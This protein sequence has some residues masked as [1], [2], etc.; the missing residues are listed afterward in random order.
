M[1]HFKKQLK[2][3][4]KRPVSDVRKVIKNKP[5][6]LRND[7]FTV[8][9][10]RKAFSEF[11]RKYRKLTTT[12][13]IVVVIWIGILIQHRIT[14]AETTMFFPNACLGGWENP[15][16]ASG[17]PTLQGGSTNNDFNK[18]NSAVLQANSLSELYCGEFSGTVPDEAQP[19]KVVLSLSGVIK[20]EQAKEIET[21]PII[22][23]DNATSTVEEILSSPAEDNN[24]VIITEVVLPENSPSESETTEL[25]QLNESDVNAKP[26]QSLPPE[27]PSA[28]SEE[29]SAPDEINNLQSLL[30]P[31]I[32]VAYAS[33]ATTSIDVAQS[34][35]D[36]YQDAVLEVFYTLDTITWNSL[37]KVAGE[38]IQITQFE[39]PSDAIADWEDL[40]SL[41]I[42]VARVTSIDESPTLLID[43]MTLEVT[44]DEINPDALSQRQLIIS[45]IGKSL[46]PISMSKSTDSGNYFISGPP[47]GLALY[48][49]LTEELIYTTAIDQNSVEIDP[50]L[51]NTP[52][53]YVFISTRHVNWCSQLTLSQCK[54]DSSYLG[55][56]SFTVG[57]LR[58][59]ALS[60]SATTTEQSVTTDSLSTTTE[61]NSNSTS[62]ELFPSIQN[63]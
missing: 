61:S 9:F 28:Q 14:R 55:E 51:I 22:S 56:A 60:N 29:P 34:V 23:T 7:P 63:L 17:K 40:K 46:G 15:Q 6:S 21:E 30:S 8:E 2:R 32:P 35:K 49:A 33:D 47:S 58:P 26:D 37:G 27:Q 19:K 25:E 13:G 57:V 24:S 44:Y 50:A 39:F 54:S 31:L 1:N 36:N 20:R 18:D 10:S 5:L 3:K 12:F 11:F 16:H 43:G 45:S 41:Q 38:K 59:F 53:S 4:N 52:G 62:T 42:K 48:N